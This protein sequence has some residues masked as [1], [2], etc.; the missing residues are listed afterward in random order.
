[1]YQK[2][3]ASPYEDNYNL[4]AGVG[5]ESYSKCGGSTAILNVNSEVRITPITSP[6]RGAMT[7]SHLFAP[8]GQNVTIGVLI[9]HRS[10]HSTE[11]CTSSLARTGADVRFDACCTTYATT[12][13]A[14]VRHEGAHRSVID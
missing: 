13:S 4:L 6:S 1:V 2:N 3:I 9:I 12:R 5:I 7:V 11:V 10:T 8:C 14:C